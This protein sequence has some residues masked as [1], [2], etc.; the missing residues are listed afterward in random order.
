[1]R[2]SQ[3]DPKNRIELK[4]ISNKN[5]LSIYKKMLIMDGLS[6]NV[7]YGIINEY[8]LHHLNICATMNVKHMP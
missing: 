4:F 6:L 2:I 3:R 5:N 1:M 7:Y 8:G